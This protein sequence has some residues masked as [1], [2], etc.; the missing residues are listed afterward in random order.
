MNRKELRRKW[1]VFAVL[2]LLVFIVSDLSFTFYH[3]EVHAAIFNQYG[4]NYTKGFMFDKDTY[5]L[6]TFY[7][8][9]TDSSFR[10]CNEVCGSL[11]TE[12]EIISYNFMNTII[13]LW[14]IL[15]ILLVKSFIEDNI[16]INNELEYGRNNRTT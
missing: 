2:F 14:S 10:M 16:K 8:Q 3:E 13:V 15:F 9:S 7:V 4:V 11:Q 1:L 6:P 12:N 5:Y